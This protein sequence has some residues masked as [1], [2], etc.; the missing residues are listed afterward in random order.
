MPELLLEDRYRAMVLD[1]L[2]GQA[3]DAELWAFGSRTAG[4]A[5]AGSDLDLVLRNPR[6]PEKPLPGMAAI[7]AAFS[8]SDIPI[9][10]DVHDW[11]RLPPSFR[12][13]IERGCIQLR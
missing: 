10:V 2:A 13:E 3:I 4:G 9:I 5:H 6:E 8:E 7:R 11:A 12:R 1:I